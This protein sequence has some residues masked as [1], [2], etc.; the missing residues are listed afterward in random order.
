M[1]EWDIKTESILHKFNISKQYVND[2]AVCGTDREWLI[3]AARPAGIELFEPSLYRRLG[4]HEN[5]AALVDNCMEKMISNDVVSAN[6]AINDARDKLSTSELRNQVTTWFCQVT[7]GPQKYTGR[8]MK[9]AHQHL[10]ITEK[11]WLAMVADLKETLNM[12]HIPEKEQKELL[13]IV[14]NTKRD[15]QI[16]E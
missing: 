8:S 3:A 1:I 15:V 4:G 12:F 2:I 7:G 14:E 6:P 10:N 11:E 13:A 16:S 5:I 9:K